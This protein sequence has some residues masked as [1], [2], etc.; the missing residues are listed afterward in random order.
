MK[1][2]VLIVI[3]I[4]II[5]LI[6]LL[7]DCLVFN[8]CKFIEPTYDN[9]SDWQ[10][11]VDHKDEYPSSLIKLA[12]HNKE[13]I[14][15]VAAYP[16]QSK[17][18]FSLNL[19]DDLK[20]RDM[21]HFLQWDQRWGY[22]KYGDDF[23]AIN[24][25]GPTALSMVAS[26]LTDNPSY[27][28]YYIAQYAYQRGY[29]TKEGT[30]W[31]LMKEGAIDLGLKVTELGLDEQVLIHSLNQS[32][33]IICSVRAGIFTTTGHFIVIKEYKDGL[34]YVYDP[35]SLLKSKG[36]SYQELHSQIKNLWSYSL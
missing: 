29:Y 36:Y 28:P 35:N 16:H 5:P 9:S 3:A 1:K 21:P 15:F 10:Y 26:Y 27:N 14:A 4:V 32:A 2:K 33:P 12:L 6:I 18:Y 19:T 22:K 25:C 13:A 17:V 30:S 8:D 24:G 20:N 23:M 11:I 7:L 34:F 31:K